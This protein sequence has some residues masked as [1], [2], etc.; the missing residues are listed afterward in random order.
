MANF[1]SAAIFPPEIVSGQYIEILHEAICA[2][3]G[4]PL[5]FSAAKIERSSSIFIFLQNVEDYTFELSSLL[6]ICLDHKPSSLN[7]MTFSHICL[8]I[9]LDLPMLML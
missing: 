1:T 2:I 6:C 5:P 9:F 3:R 4:L 8:D 7:F